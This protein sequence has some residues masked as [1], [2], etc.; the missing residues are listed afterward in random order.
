MFLTFFETEEV[1]KRGFDIA[2]IL[3]KLKP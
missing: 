1:K 3:R 2:L